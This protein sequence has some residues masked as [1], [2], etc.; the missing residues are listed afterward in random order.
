MV[1]VCQL[2]TYAVLL[3]L[4]IFIGLLLDYFLSNALPQACLYWELWTSTVS[5]SD[6]NMN[7]C[8]LYSLI[9]L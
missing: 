7:I 9:P 2:Q 6:G 1:G 8:R 5:P 4:R 3:L